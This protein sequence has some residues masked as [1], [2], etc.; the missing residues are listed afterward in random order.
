MLVAVYICTSGTNV[1]KILDNRNH[2]ECPCFNNL[3]DTHAGE[4][5]STLAKCIE[6]QMEKLEDKTGYTM[7]EL[8]KIKK[9]CNGINGDKVEKEGIKV[10]KGLGLSD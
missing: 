9:W 10:A 6:G 7:K 1:G 8:E 5:K 2:D 3:I 4:L